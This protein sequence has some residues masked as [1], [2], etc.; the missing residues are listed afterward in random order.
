MFR[1]VN[2]RNILL[3]A[4]D[5]CSRLV[6]TD[7][8]HATVS[9][10]DVA[11]LRRRHESRGCL[12]SDSAEQLSSSSSLTHAVVLMVGVVLVIQV[13]VEAVRGS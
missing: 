10:C 5:P 1:D 12:S 9:D 13:W 4:D 7:F 6:L 8:K 11:G 2:C 3:S